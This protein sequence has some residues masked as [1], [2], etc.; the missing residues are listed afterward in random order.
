MAWVQPGQGTDQKKW[1]MYANGLV[2]NLTS[3]NDAENVEHGIL[4]V[5]RGTG[6]AVSSIALGNLTDLPAVNIQSRLMTVSFSNQTF[7][8]TGASALL[9]DNA[10]A[11]GQTPIDFHMNGVLTGRI[12]NDFAG[13]IN[14]VSMASGAHNFFSG[15]DAGVGNVTFSVS[16]DGHA[17]LYPNIW[18]TSQVDLV[19]RMFFGLNATTYY[20]SA[21]GHEWRTSTSTAIM[22]LSS[23]GFLG[24]AAT[25]AGLGVGTLSGLGKLA[26]ASTSGSFG[27]VAAWN[28]SSSI[29]GPNVGSG[30]GAA[31]G[32]GYDASIDNA[33]I[34]ALAPSVAWKGLTISASQILFAVN[35]ATRSSMLYFV[36]GQ[37][38][39]RVIV[40]NGG[41]AAGTAEGDITLIW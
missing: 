32:L 17:S 14:Y 6:M 9:L 12:R 34:Q 39:G 31:L 22:S 40:Q 29:F 30:T 18:H 7:S 33:V 13:N 10:A 23:G 1:Q 27:G 35:G 3:L 41:S 38:S 4:S 37:G 11:S 21:T 36:G 19:P 25:G 28:S 15:G 20:N 16:A 2:L 24:L 5:L 8:P 26:V